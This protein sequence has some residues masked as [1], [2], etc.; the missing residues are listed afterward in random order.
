MIT[1]FY[2]QNCKICRNIKFALSVLDTDR[3]LIFHPIQND[4]IYIDF[5][6]LNYWDCR[7]TIHIIDQNNQIKNG[8]EAIEEILNIINILNKAK[9]VYQSPIGRIGVKLFYK[10]LNEYRLKL[11]SECDDCRN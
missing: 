10:Y 7:R 9:P 4:Q 1:V 2:D 8:E 6:Q 11:V 5:P 3:H